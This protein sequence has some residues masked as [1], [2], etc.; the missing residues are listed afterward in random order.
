MLPIDLMI[1]PDQRVPYPIF[2]DLWSVQLRPCRNV[3]VH[4]AVL[5]NNGRNVLR[6]P[7]SDVT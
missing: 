2:R 6:E 1:E 5:Q 7:G 4:T 3:D